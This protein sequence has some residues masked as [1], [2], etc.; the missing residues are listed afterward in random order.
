[1]VPPT[2]DGRYY[3]LRPELAVPRRSAL[4]LNGFFAFHPQLRPL[5]EH[6]RGGRLAV[7]HAFGSPH[8]T[9]SHFEAQDFLESGAPGNR[10]IQSGW[11]GRYAAAARLGKPWAALTLGARP[12]RA[13][14]GASTSL[15]FPSIEKF[16]M[17]LGWDSERRATFERIVAGS[18]DEWQGS[19]RN[20]FGALREI[21]D[22]DVRPRVRWP[23]GDLA[24]ALRD[25]SI[26]IRARIGVRVAAVDMTGWDH[27]FD[28]AKHIAES[29]ATLA[30]ALDA[31]VADLGAEL[32]RTLVLVL[33]EFGRS[34]PQ[35]GSGGTEHG[36]GGALLAL[37]GGV[38]GG[39]VFLRNGQWPGLS[40]SQLL[41]GRDLAVTTDFRD[42]FAEVLRRHMG[43]S[44]LRPIF[45]EFS[46]S[47][48]RFPGLLG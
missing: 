23:S 47:T 48:S 18:D 29:A 4:D 27:H 2:G 46:V 44:D 40:A 31:F 34:A 14:A 13:L 16:G 15:A 22:V 9:R 26:L 25:L 5:H 42:A 24:T 6:Y 20:S 32:S 10:T 3:T 28:L 36:R 30:L 17:S 19:A 7:V 38:R 41:Q 35:N 39:R 1:M 43:V 45:P 11:L 12:A 33:S 21:Q 8:Q 37:G